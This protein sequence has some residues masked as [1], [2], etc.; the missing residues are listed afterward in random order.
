M[1]G[2]LHSEN[3]ANST[4][5]GSDRNSINNELAKEEAIRVKEKILDEHKAATPTDAINPPLAGFWKRKPKRDPNEIATQISVFDDPVQAKYFK[6]SEK[7]E[8][9][10]RFDP[11]F[12][13]TWGDERVCHFCMPKSTNLTYVRNLFEKLT[14]KS[15][16]GPFVH[17]SP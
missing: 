4:S 8:N 12:K 14:G 11:D 17:F 5:S 13:W 7:Y 15:L 10:H 6:P 1:A 9:L 3:K 2:S 16:F